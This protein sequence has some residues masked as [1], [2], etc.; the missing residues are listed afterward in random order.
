VKLLLDMNLSPRWVALLT[1]A[2]IGAKVIM[3]LRQ[4]RSELKAG[5]ILTVEVNRMR[6]RILPLTDREGH[7]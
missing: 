4:T 2:G 7:H 5:A 6:L 3:A 1:E